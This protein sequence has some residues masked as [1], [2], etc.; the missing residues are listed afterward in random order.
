MEKLYLCMKKRS[1]QIEM[2]EPLMDRA[3]KSLER[4]LEMS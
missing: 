3:R 1:P 4:M 2:P